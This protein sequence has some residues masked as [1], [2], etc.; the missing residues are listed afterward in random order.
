VCLRQALR[1]DNTDQA[2]GKSSDHCKQW[3][4]D[5]KPFLAQVMQGIWQSRQVFD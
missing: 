1:T 3:I 5:Q 2:S 4:Q